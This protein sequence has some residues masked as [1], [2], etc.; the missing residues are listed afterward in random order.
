VILWYCIH[1][2][3]LVAFIGFWCPILSTP[4][5]FEKF[6]IGNSTCSNC[7]KKIV[8]FLKLCPCTLWDEPHP[9]C[10][11][12][13]D[14][15]L[16]EVKHIN[17]GYYT[18]CICCTWVWSLSHLDSTFFFTQSKAFFIP[19]LFY[20]QVAQIQTF[21]EVWSCCLRPPWQ[22]DGCPRAK[23]TQLHLK[24]MCLVQMCT[25]QALGCIKISACIHLATPSWAFMNPF[26]LFHCISMIILHWR[27]NLLMC[28][29]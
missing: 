10:E 25:K 8:I 2:F 12:A 24:A 17:K 4:C 6:C 1:F 26:I 19:F 28:K 16:L 15:Q 29:I 22:I 7:F 27:R 20:M 11:N 21:I 14:A 9:L 18:S 23:S 5:N 3:C 13:N